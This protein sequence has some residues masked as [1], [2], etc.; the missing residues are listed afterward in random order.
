MR[1]LGDLLRTATIAGTLCLASVPASRAQPSEMPGWVTAWATSMQDPLPT[2]FPVGNPPVDLRNG[3]R[4]SLATAHP[5]RA[6]G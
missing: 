4:C 5:T 1:R 2:G 3:H 6:S